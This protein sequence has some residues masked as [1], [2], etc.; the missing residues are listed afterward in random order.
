MADQPLILIVDDEENFREIFGAK[1]SSA[2]FRVET[3]EDGEAAIEKAVRFMPSLILMDVKMPGM[4]G[5]SVILKLRENPDLMKVKIAFLTSLADPIAMTDDFH[6]RLSKEF[7]AVRYFRKTDDLD[8]LV[9]GIR[10]I[11]GMSQGVL[12]A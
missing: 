1:L 2:G 9:T 6:D 3:A 12:S 5:P 11:L 8:L 10:E 7:G 4:E